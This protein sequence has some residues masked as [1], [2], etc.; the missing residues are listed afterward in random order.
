MRQLV[1]LAALFLVILVV[2]L[3]SYNIIG[4]TMPEASGTPT[5]SGDARVLVGA[6][7]IATCPGEG[8]EETAELLDEVVADWPDAVV[9]T[10]GDNV[11]PGGAI[12]EY[13]E[14]FEPTWGRHRARTRPAVGNH[15]FGETK[16]A[17]Y[18]EY[19]GERGGEFDQYYYS[20]DVGAWHIVVL[21]S[22]CHRVGCDLDSPDGAQ[23]EWLI[24]DLE[25]SDAS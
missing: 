21:N 5:S 9:F 22:E 7:D 17:G 2:G 13:R 6:G 15:D 14:C 19:W 10:T 3:L 24:E 1:A 12:E 11:Y 20:Y 18:H 4:W 8:D 16:A 25:A 23:A